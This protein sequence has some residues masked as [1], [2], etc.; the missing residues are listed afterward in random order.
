M[1]RILDEVV[2]LV[3]S[4]VL[5]PREY[6]V[7]E[8]AVWQL[9]GPVYFVELSLRRYLQ[10][11]FHHAVVLMSERTRVAPTTCRSPSKCPTMRGKAA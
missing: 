10:P 6:V 8:Y 9:V 7:R 3:D 11:G 2:V 1:G 5:S 4:E